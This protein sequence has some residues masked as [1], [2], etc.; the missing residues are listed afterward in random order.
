MLLAN[1]SVLDLTNAISR[2]TLEETKELVFHMG[3]PLKDIDNITEWYSDDMQKV[4]L[5]QKWLDMDPDASWDQLITGLREIG[6]NALATEI[7]SQQGLSWSAAASPPAHHLMLSLPSDTFDEK[8]TKV[9]A[10]IETL[11]EEFSLLKYEAQRLLCKREQKDKAFFYKFQNYLLDMQITA[12]HI[13]FFTRNKDEILK[14]K[15]IQKLFAI[16]DRYC[17]YF[18]YEIISHIVK[19]F[20]PELKGRMLK[21][22]NTYTVFEKTTTVNVFLCA[23]SA[24]P[25]GEI[26]QGFLRM[27]MKI[28][29]PSTEC[30]LENIQ[31]MKKAIEEAAQLQSYTMYIGEPV[32]G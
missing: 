25:G 5:V 17:N 2:L 28:N 19:K 18:N 26:S 8:V 23:I 16:L 4:H 13:Q 3:V 31:K 21:Y 15:T 7:E 9:R 11:K 10:N 27:T 12:T 14:A 6:K 20:C 1:L 30:T 32:E 24:R 22:R 29:K